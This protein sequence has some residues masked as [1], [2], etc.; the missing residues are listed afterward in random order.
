[1]NTTRKN[2]G[3][4]ATSNIVSVRGRDDSMNDTKRSQEMGEKSDL[5]PLTRSIKALKTDDGRP[6]FVHFTNLKNY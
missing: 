5:G 2:L 1:M 3:D 6:R 4:Q